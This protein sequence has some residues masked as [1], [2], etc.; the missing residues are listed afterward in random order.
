MSKIPDKLTRI[1][2]KATKGHLEKE[3]WLFRSR[4]I[5]A[6]IQKANLEISLNSKKVTIKSFKL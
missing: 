3:W 5:V 2:K 1:Q 4:S 6:I